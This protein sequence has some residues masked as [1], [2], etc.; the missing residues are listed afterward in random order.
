M[1]VASDVPLPVL[2]AR[3]REARRARGMS[4][5]DA[6]AGIGVSR[7][8]L[9]AVEQGKRVPTA[10]ELVDFARLYGRDVHELVRDTPPVEALTARFRAAEQGSSD[11]R[12]AVDEL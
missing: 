2:G 9:I 7:H 11:T 3:L 6:A 8:T 1:T 12:A 4:Q 5:A 10:A